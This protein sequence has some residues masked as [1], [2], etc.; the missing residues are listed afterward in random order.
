M[1]NYSRKTNKKA[2]HYNTPSTFRV[3]I[4][5]FNKTKYE[6]HSRNKKTD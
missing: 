3:N 4:N 5:K 6:I 1:K 2:T